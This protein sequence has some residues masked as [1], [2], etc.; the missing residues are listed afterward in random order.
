MSE[1][2]TPDEADAFLAE[3]GEAELAA[4]KAENAALKEQILR[5][6]A[7]AE[8]TK[9]RA[10]RE[11]NDARAY[12]IQKFARD[13]LGV[14][15]NLSR[16]LAHEPA[17]NG[18]A[19]VKNFVLGIEMTEKELLGAFERNG[20]KRIA[21][22]RAEKFDPHQHQA[23]AEVPGTDVAAGGIVEVMQPGFELLGRL[24]RPAMVVVA[25]K[26]SSAQPE[27]AKPNGAGPNPYAGGDD[28]D[29]GGSVDRRA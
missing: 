27:G 24:L 11:A 16:A 5:Y 8:N 13:L 14:A 3:A 10:E 18:D 7:E 6:A 9:R 23:M 21:P 17:D 25:A 22:L 2:D 4:L 12:A 26:E 1:D 19:V 15:D 20:L 29:P 28:A